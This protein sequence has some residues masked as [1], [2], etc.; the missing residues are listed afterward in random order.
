MSTLK[1]SGLIAKAIQGL[2]VRADAALQT[3][4]H[5]VSEAVNWDG[6]VAPFFA[7]LKST[8]LFIQLETTG[9]LLQYSSSHHKNS[10]T[11]PT[12]FICN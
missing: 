11:C 12:D 1:I 3:P 8:A 4:T 2:L 6:I 5:V 9:P 10:V 7:M